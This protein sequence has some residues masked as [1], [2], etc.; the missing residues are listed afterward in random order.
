MWYDSHFERPKAKETKINMSFLVVMKQEKYSPWPNFCYIVETDKRGNHYLIMGLHGVCFECMPET[1]SFY[2]YFYKKEWTPKTC[3][4]WQAKELLLPTAENIF[5]SYIL[6]S[7]LLQISA[8]NNEFYCWVK[9]I[10]FIF[11]F[12]ETI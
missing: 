7:S 2:N 1:I 9:C 6:I 5:C 11:T 8:I 4:L 3:L 10:F 12:I